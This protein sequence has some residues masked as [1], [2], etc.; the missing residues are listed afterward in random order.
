MLP[1]IL[2]MK[3][4]NPTLR[5]LKKEHHVAFSGFPCAVGLHTSLSLGSSICGGA[6]L[7][8]L[9]LE[10]AEGV[11]GEVPALLQDSML[12]PAALQGSDTLPGSTRIN[13]PTAHLYGPQRVSRRSDWLCRKTLD[14]LQQ[15]LHL[16]VAAGSR[17]SNCPP[18]TFRGPSYRELTFCKGK[19]SD[20][21]ADPTNG[22]SQAGKKNP[23]KDA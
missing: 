3:E 10:G 17:R 19:I 4:S 20:G 21:E 7:I 6:D 1:E 11:N 23:Y 15:K 14:F 12:R 8:L 9:L 2:K 22:N 5:Q 13:V 18:V 16:R